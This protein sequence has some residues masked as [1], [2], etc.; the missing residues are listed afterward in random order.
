MAESAAPTLL[1]IRHHGPGSARSVLAALTALQPDL[2]LVEGPPDAQDLLPLVIDPDLRPPVAL[3]LY[4]PG[5]PRHAVYYP[6]ASFSPEWQ[7]IR[8]GL[9]QGVP[10][11][12]MDLPQAV[13]LAL[14]INA[15]TA[16]VPEAAAD[17]ADEVETV[18]P[19]AEPPD[20]APPPAGPQGPELRRDPLRWVA[21]AAGYGDGERWWE[22]QVELRQD[23]SEL[24]QAIGELMGAL[25][26]AADAEQPPELLEQ[27][28]EAAMRTQ[29]RAAQKEG[30]QRIAVVCGAWH[31][32]ALANMPPARTDAALL[33]GLPKRKLA[34]TWVPWT[35]GRLTQ[36]SGYGAGVAAPGFYQHLWDSVGEPAPR[37]LARIAQL[38]REQDLSASTASVIEATRLAEALA[39]LRAR[40][41]PTL[42]E[43]NEATLAVLCQGDAAPLRLI[44]EQ[45]LIGECLGVVPE[46][47]PMLPLQLDLQRQQKRLRLPPEA[48]Q[49]RLELDL[50]QPNDLERSQLLHRLN[51]LGIA[52]GQPEQA[53]GKGTFKEHWRLQWQPE[54]ALAVIEA[55]LWGNS[56]ADAASARARDQ[57][58]KSD[59]LSALTALVE[60]TLLAALPSATHAVMALLQDRAALTHDIPHLMESLP[61]LARVLR[62]GDVRQTD[63]SR[64]GPV[65]AGLVTRIAIGLP[66]A[67]SALDD[68]AAAD[69][70]AHLQTT[71]AAVALLQEAGQTAIWQG[72]LARLADQVGLHGLVA[73]HTCRLLFE[74]QVFDAAETGRRMGLALSPAGDVARAAAW[75][76]GFLHGSGLLLLHHEGLWQLLDA[77]L[78]GLSG[79]AFTQMLPLLRR[80]FSGFAAP[81]RR[82]LGERVQRGSSG[83]G[84]PGV[85]THVDVARADQVLPLAAR[86]LGLV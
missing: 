44:E 72:A 73:G 26:A 14:E 52:W 5:E 36:A 12:F 85:A 81:E 82:Q 84:V 50:R 34:A 9:Q 11:R 15:A 4:D 30:F 6:F 41:R 27:Q 67:C 19:I 86:L 37:W 80:T 13:R 43:L 83:P 54:L 42:D 45:L 2:I 17:G 46:H 28:R 29:L 79:T 58:Q 39:A 38:L 7:A 8:Y 23:S 55:S 68:A 53:S 60:Q 61:P 65:V 20:A 40:P 63:A 24:F 57:A 33:K 47:T 16:A 59:Q 70:F 64:V 10:V 66:A 76:E 74:Q 31:V 32:P 56:V 35:H 78:C 69:M 77:W 21:E 49:R 22:H 48:G 51:L 75:L 18:Q 25:R 1:G 3:L 62:Y 71:Q